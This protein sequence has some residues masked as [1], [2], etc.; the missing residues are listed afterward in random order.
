[1]NNEETKILNQSE[2]T[3]VINQQAEQQ[4]EYNK[5]EKT[6]AEEPKMAVESTK[7][8]NIAEKVAYA[9]GGFAAGVATG[10]STSAFASSGEEAEVPVI[11]TVED[12]NIV[13]AESAQVEQEASQA[14]TTTQNSAPIESN[15]T[16][17]QEVLI[18]E[19]P[20]PQEAI[21]AT[22]DGMKVA[23]VNDE[24][25]FSEAFADAR[26]QV[27]AGGVFE[28]RGHVYN[29]YYESEWDNMSSAERAE[30]QSKVDYDAVTEIEAS[31]ESPT[32]NMA[33]NTINV[34]STEAEQPTIAENAEMIDTQS[35][36]TGVKVLGVEVVADS[37]GNQMTIAGLEIEGQ[38]A[39]MVDVDNDGMMDLICVDENADGQLSE[40]EIYD[41]R[42][43]GVTTQDLMEQM[44]DD[45]LY[46][47]QDDSMPDYMND[48][49]V[50]TLV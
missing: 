20:T 22:S 43:L 35:E 8:K 23:Q 27:G 18:E 41:A 45:N 49:D 1:M 44:P 5:E 14:T 46:Y 31:V 3:K 24:V 26:A 17:P 40:N 9:A 2:E 7:K 19:A 13:Q 21:I 29:T 34:E 37:E 50:S 6:K 15:T 32:N 38:G 25:S 12:E 47:A 33:Q 36:D 30:F 4:S 10:A 42:E 39:I 11:E 48:A 16:A 28:W